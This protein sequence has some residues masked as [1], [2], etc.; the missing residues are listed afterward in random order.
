MTMESDILAP[1]D[2]V[3]PLRD[4]LPEH[5]IRVLLIDDQPII[6]EAVRRML[7]REGDIH[8]HYCQDPCLAVDMANDIEPTVIL[9]DLLMPDVDG[10]ELVRRFRGNE[11]TRQ[12]PLIVLSSREDGHTKA[13]AFALGANDYLVKLP[14]PIELVARIR[15]HSAA[16]IHLM[17]RDEAY[18][19][20][21][22]SRNRLRADLAEAVRYVESLLPEPLDGAVRAAWT[23]VPSASL[24]G[25]T[26]GYHWHDE[27]HFALYLLDVA[28]HGVGAA[29][30]SV[31]ALNVLRSESLPKTDFKQP[32]E[33]ITR[34]SEKFQ[35][36]RQSGKYFTI[37]YGVYQKSS[38]R[39]RYA[40]GGHPPAILLPDAAASTPCL[41]LES[42]GP[43]PGILPGMVWPGA[44]ADV[45]PGARLFLFSDGI[46]EIERNDG[47][48]WDYEGFAEVVA[49]Y[50]A[51]DGA[52][53]ERIVQHVMSISGRP[54]FEDDV[55]LVTFD[56][57]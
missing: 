5:P 54:A 22:V 44:E 57:P 12:T 50:G 27:D 19:A 21:V 16:Y 14:D 38:R 46:Y 40:G 23:F 9:S 52:C 48:L 13:E 47:T 1:L 25:D 11:T 39:L 17:Q 24:G 42:T 36:E 43:M 53:M 15:Y 37:W 2:G 18:G 7:A 29:L 32:G 49:R 45:P 20:L 35:M 31:S 30:L 41:N 28:G 4:A 34:L 56:F 51:G 55:S 3:D 8:F 6:A 26:F 10:L 33:V